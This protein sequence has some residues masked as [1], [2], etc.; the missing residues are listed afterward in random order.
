MLGAFLGK[1]LNLSEASINGMKG[2]KDNCK[3]TLL[4][5]LLTEPDETIVRVHDHNWQDLSGDLKV[6][7]KNVDMQYG[8]HDDCV[9]NG[10]CGEYAYCVN[11]VR[12]PSVQMGGCIAGT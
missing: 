2:A 7:V 4:I 8:P 11:V 5:P 9:M 6:N 1:M 10:E 12:Y 3:V